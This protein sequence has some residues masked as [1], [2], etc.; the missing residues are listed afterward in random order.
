MSMNKNLSIPFV[1]E[2]LISEEQHLPGTLKQRSFDF[3]F[4]TLA[5]F[6]VISF[7][8]KLKAYSTDDAFD[9]SHK[10]GSMISMLK[11]R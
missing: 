2:A 8:L 1:L 10:M 3:D 9:F 6:F 7:T 4:K 5:S 11:D